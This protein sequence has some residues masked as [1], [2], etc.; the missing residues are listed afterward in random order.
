MVAP[1]TLVGDAVVLRAFAPGELEAMWRYVGA[2]G[3]DRER[4]ERSV[5]SSGD[6][7]DGLLYLAVEHR[8]RFAGA[9]DARALGGGVFELGIELIEE[10]RGA[11]AGTAAVE[12]LTEHLL[13]DGGAVRVQA[14]TALDNAAMRR[15]LEKAAFAF[16]GELPAHWRGRDYALYARTN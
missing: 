8:A 13:R 14:S 7:A 11:G 10:A 2:A 9:I 12:L 1:L 15:V 5:R 6:W 16:E 4:L 3:G